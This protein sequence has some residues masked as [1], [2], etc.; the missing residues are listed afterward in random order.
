MSR[1][2]IPVALATSVVLYSPFAHAQS[3]QRA[4]AL[5]SVI[6]CKA[7]P[8]A[9]ARLACYDRAVEA[10]D[11][12][13]RTGEVTV[14]DRE[15]VREARSRLF[16]FNVGSLSLFDRPGETKVEALETTLASARQQGRGAWVFTLADGSVWRQIDSEQISGTP[17]AGQSV[18]IREA[19]MG[20]Y[21]LSVNGARSVRARR[22]Q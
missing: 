9:D 2:L 20:S 5:T 14:V 12:A 18:R 13:E 1:H 15:Q 11:A 8:E 21:M 7:I 3:Q 6:E 17:R 16:G 19:A 4:P 10:L 22:E